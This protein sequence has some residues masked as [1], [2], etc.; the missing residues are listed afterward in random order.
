MDAR[1]A[2][3][4]AHEVEE[5]L[6]ARRRRRRVVRIVEERAGRAGQEDR[7]V[8]L[9]VRLVDVGGIVGDRRASRRRSSCPSPRSSGRR[10]E[11]TS[12]RTQPALPSTSTLRGCFGLAG[13]VAGSAAIIACTCAGIGRLVLRLRPRPPPGNPPAGAGAGSAAFKP[14]R[15]C[16]CV[17]APVLALSHSVNHLSNVALHLVARDGAV[18]VGVDHGK[19]GRAGVAAP[20]ATTTTL[21]GLPCGR[22]GRLLRRHPTHAARHQRCR[23][24]SHGQQ[25]A[26]GG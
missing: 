2:L 16:S 9:E 24:S 23:A 3:A 18:L 7:V 5:R 22:L 12:A 4:A 6:P 10:A 13:A 17:S 15:S 8:L 25:I 19:D 1:E 14:A 11:S 21:L 20:A 26:G